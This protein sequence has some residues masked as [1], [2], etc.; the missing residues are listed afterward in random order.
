MMQRKMIWQE[1][2]DK[3][4]VTCHKHTMVA[5]VTTQAVLVFL[6]STEQMIAGVLNGEENLGTR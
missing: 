2:P 1:L 5:I 4:A 3:Q 6:Q